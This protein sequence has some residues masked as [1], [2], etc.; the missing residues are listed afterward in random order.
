MSAIRQLVFKAR[1]GFLA[2][3]IVIA[4]FITV[5]PAIANTDISDIPMSVKNNVAP[6]IMFTLDDSGSMYWEVIPDFDANFPLYYLFPQATNIYGTSDNYLNHVV[7][8][9]PTNRNVRFFR[10]A[11]GNP[12]YYNPAVRYEPWRNADGTLWPN[13][14]PLAAAMNPA[15]ATVVPAVNLQA[16]F[17]GYVHRRLNADDTWTVVNTNLTFWPATYFVYAGPERLTR[18]GT[19]NTPAN[20]RQIEIRSGQTYDGRTVYPRRTDCGATCTYEQ[21]LQNFANWFSY[22]RSRILAARAGIGKAFSQQKPDLRIGFASIN[23]EA[24][25]IDGVSTRRVLRGVRPFRDAARTEF[26]DL[27]YQRPFEALGTP[28]RAAADDIG[29]YFARSDAGSPWRRDPAGR[30]SEELSCFKNFHI[31]MTDGYWSMESPAR[32]AINDQNVDSIAGPT[33][34]H[35]DGVRSYT[36]SPAHP[37]SDAHS[38]TLADVA[39]HY[40][41]NDLRSGLTNNVPSDPRNPAFWQHLSTYTVGFGVSGTLTPTQ[42]ASAFTANPLDFTWPDPALSEAAKLDDLAHAAVNGRGAFFST[43]DPERFSTELGN[44]L[45]TINSML[46]ASAASA[47]SNPNVTITDNTTYET[48]YVPGAWTGDLKAFA[49]DLSTGAPTANS[50]WTSTAMTQLDARDPNS[51]RIATYNGSAGRAF[52]ADQL[53]AAQLNELNTAPDANNATA[54]LAYLRGDR[55]GEQTLP[56]TFRPRQNLLG[57]IIHS[58]P[59]LVRPPHR[60]FIDA[61][62]SDFR[63]ANSTRARMLY[64]G[65]NDGMMH[66]F[67]A[68]TGAEEWAYVPRQAFPR[69]KNLA[70][71]DFTFQATVD[72]Y[73]T[74]GDVNLGNTQGGSGTDWRTMLVGGLGRGGKGFFALDITAA[75]ADEA[76][77]AGKVLWEFPN[78]ATSA[79]DKNNLG[80]AFSRPIIVKHEVVAN[81]GTVSGAGWVVLVSSGYNNGGSGDGRGYLYV[82]N[83]RTGAVIR[84]I[85]TGV[86]TAANPSGLGQLSAWVDDDNV[87]NAVRWVYGGDLQGN[88]W[89]F[90][91]SSSDPANWGVVKLASLA[92]ANGAAQPITVAP[93]LARVSAGGR[94]INLVAVGTGR[95]LGDSD[96]PGTPNANSAAS[97][98]QSFYVIADS[99]GGANFQ[100]ITRTN[101]VQR[102][103]TTLNNGSRALT[104]TETVNWGSNTVKGWFVDLNI[105]GERVTTDPA[106]ANTTV[107][108]VSNVPNADPCEPGGSSHLFQFDLVTGSYA[109]GLNFLNTVS[110]FIGRTL[111]SR[112]VLVKL[113][114]GKVIALIRKSDGSTIAREIA[115]PVSGGSTRRLSW[116]ELNYR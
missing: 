11:A 98:T 73:L 69:L 44:M 36:Y 63:A 100:A 103:L 56:P 85:S 86:G 82:L 5:T 58:E 92:D 1:S 106:I 105:S 101:L 40:W 97:Q 48:S 116:R 104:S 13:V 20:F 65:A 50:P 17:S 43:S 112:P 59:V 26:F 32:A 19:S 83:A 81:N 18:T 70:A 53:S 28:L 60:S 25:D 57:A 68:Q 33:H 8:M 115:T 67:N 76:A 61:G 4:S 72:G 49:L 79:T 10:S 109:R 90:D 108:F 39:L 114:S 35:A 7:D 12:L 38:G 99:I 16:D 110:S 93:E 107:T 45:N 24:S 66:A 89:R 14:D 30:N 52:R 87:N 55:S 42:I 47:V 64:V 2:S 75:P 111:A 91:L 94:F 29:Q 23:A 22:Y 62:Y 9:D 95:Y 34:N 41:K 88:L 3:L 54:L 84:A 113:P 51:R 37:Y 96:I 31:L 6:N 21:E 27:L 78:D 77:L 46:S 80:L 102:T 71:T 74:T 15:R